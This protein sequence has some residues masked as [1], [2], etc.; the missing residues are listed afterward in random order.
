MLVLMKIIWKKIGFISNQII[1]RFQQEICKQVW[2]SNQK[3]KTKITIEIKI[4]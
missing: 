4:L 3:Y 2:N 1:K